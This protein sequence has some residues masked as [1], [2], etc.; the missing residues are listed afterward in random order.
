MEPW[1]KEALFSPVHVWIPQ[2][3][4]GDEWPRWHCSIVV[5]MAI[6]LNGVAVPYCWMQQQQ[7]S[8]GYFLWVQ[9]N[10]QSFNSSSSGTAP[11]TPFFP[12]IIFL[13][14]SHS[15]LRPKGVYW[16]VHHVQGCCWAASNLRPKATTLSRSVWL[17]GRCHILCV[18]W[19]R[20]KGNS[21]LLD[22]ILFPTLPFKAFQ[23]YHSQMKKS[24]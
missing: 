10:L 2:S 6:F 9:K 11:W 5:C 12:K 4:G 24:T 22:G 3:I 21:Y 1:T 7:R 18:K 23:P 14:A 15:S 13:T 19:W 8:F 17:F 16:L 20:S